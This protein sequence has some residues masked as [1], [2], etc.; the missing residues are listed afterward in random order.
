M[1]KLSSLLLAAVIASSTLAAD[2]LRSTVYIGAASSSIENKSMTEVVF[3]FGGDKIYDSGLIMGF[4]SEYS[5]GSIE[6]GSSNDKSGV[7]TIEVDLKGGYSPF[8]N[9]S[10]FALVAG[11]GQYIESDAAYGFGYGVGMD[12]MLTDSIILDVRYKTYSMKD[13]LLDYDYDKAVVSIR[14]RFKG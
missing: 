12:Y 4:H 8:K 6:A 2:E 11:A 1:K 9:F 5:Y 7:S 13:A 10:V 14:Y 3:G